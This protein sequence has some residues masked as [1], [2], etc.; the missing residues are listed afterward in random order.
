[1][2]GW[3]YGGWAQSRATNG[4]V[5]PWS[6]DQLVEKLSEELATSQ[7]T[8]FNFSADQPQFYRKAQDLEKQSEMYYRDK[9]E[10][11]EDEFEQ[12]ILLKI[13]EEEKRHY[14]MLENIIDFVRQPQQ[15]IGDAEW[16]KL[17]DM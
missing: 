8:P 7:S 17:N 1:M 13:A 10:E 2:S 11:S 14:F 6:I 15:W 16:N 12:K 3:W 5:K 4:A 9:A